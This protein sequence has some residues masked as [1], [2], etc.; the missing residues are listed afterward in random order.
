L[1]A[2]IIYGILLL[3]KRKCVLPALRGF[4]I[5]ARPFLQYSSLLLLKGEG[6]N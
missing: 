4:Y 1:T 2:P 5:D 6:S 3:D